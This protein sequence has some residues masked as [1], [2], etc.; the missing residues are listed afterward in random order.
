MERQYGTSGIITPSEISQLRK[1]GK[2][3][4]FAD[5]VETKERARKFEAFVSKVVLA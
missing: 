1:F 2:V 5:V 3:E 4:V